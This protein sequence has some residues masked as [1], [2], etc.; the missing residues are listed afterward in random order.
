MLMQK[1]K[2]HYAESTAVLTSSNNT[3]IVFNTRAG[4]MS[5]IFLSNDF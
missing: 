2:P 4:R 3:H 5:S 1:T